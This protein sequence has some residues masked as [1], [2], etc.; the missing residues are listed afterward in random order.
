MMKY[1]EAIAAD[2]FSIIRL[3]LKSHSI[4]ESDGLLTD[5]RNLETAILDSNS[6]WILTEIEGD[7]VAMISSRIDLEQRIC[8]ITRM[9][10]DPDA[11]NYQG[12]TKNSLRHFL[13]YLRHKFPGIDVIF[14]TTVTMTLA[15]QK[16][17]LDEG[18]SIFGVFPNLLGED[19]S[20]LNGV[21]ALFCND[22]LEDHRQ[23]SFQL[24]HVI[25][26]FFKIAQRQVNLADVLIAS[27]A[28]VQEK[29]KK[30]GSE[31]DQV[32]PALECIDAP[33]FVKGRFN[34]HR[35]RQSQIVSFYPFYSPN[36]LIT[37]PEQLC[38][39]FIKISHTIKFA[40]I[41]GEH[42]ALPINPVKLYER[43]LQILRDRGISYIEIINDAADIFGVECILQS[44]FTPCAYL[45]A[46][47]LQGKTRRDYVVFGKSFEYLCRPDFNAHKAYIDFY[48]EYFKIEGKNYFPEQIKS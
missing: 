40:A 20:Q 35:F 21:S 48:R 16:V 11:A 25:G 12:V 19:N 44:G 47:K 22:V 42:L 18:F 30:F 45:P 37:D 1:R 15:Q 28:D 38:E 39:I 14:T 9:L 26:P 43:T 31:F 10:T 29:V 33:E 24:H 34:S 36:C 23:G 27:P 7:T 13:T 46:F 6:L 3:Y 41:I 4:D 5:Y 32:I 2:V 8:K 17:T